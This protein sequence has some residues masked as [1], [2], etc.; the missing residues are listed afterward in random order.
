MYV[1]MYIHMYVYVLSRL[2]MLCFL[3]SHLSF[4]NHAHKDDMRFST[5]EIWD[6]HMGP[7]GWASRGIRLRCEWAKLAQLD[8]LHVEL[9]SELS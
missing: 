7:S 2:A 5:L 8:Q 4:F 9:N 1:C 6:G 3:A